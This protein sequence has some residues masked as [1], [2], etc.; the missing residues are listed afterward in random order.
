[1][2]L[3]NHTPDPTG[4]IPEADAKR[5]AEFGAEVKRRFGTPIAETAG[6]GDAVELALAKGAAIDHVIAM[7]DIL[8]GERVRQYVIEGFA[9]GQWVKLAEGSAIGHKKIDR[10]D[11]RQVSKVRLRC[12]KSAAEPQIRRLAAY[13]A[14]LPTTAVAGK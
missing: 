5:A 10:F 11:P 14:G 3:L 13:Q 12:L 2:L 8:Q 4:L 1:V 7:E 6:K 9:D